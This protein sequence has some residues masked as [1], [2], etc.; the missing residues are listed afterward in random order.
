MNRGRV[1]ARGFTLIELMI[2]V[3]IIAITAAIALP[4]YQ[5]QI[6]KTRRGVAKADLIEL[7]SFMQRFYT[8]NN[9]F[10]QDRAGNAVALPFSESPTD[11][12]TKFYDLTVVTAQSTY[13]LTA[14]PKGAQ[15]GDSCAT[16][17]VAHTG[18]KTHSSGSNCW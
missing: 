3:A 2:V 7:T 5:N 10:D 9:R 13:T 14:A 8:E 11:G 6:E 17:T 18:A 4:S 1:K 15:S 12:A 16:L